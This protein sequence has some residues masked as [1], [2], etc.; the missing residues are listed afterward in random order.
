M[1]MGITCDPATC[2]APTQNILFTNG[3]YWL[4]QGKV[5]GTSSFIERL[6]TPAFLQ[7]IKL[8]L[9]HLCTLLGVY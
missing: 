1:P 3:W 2:C 8:L 9:F 4:Y 6:S 5:L 7:F